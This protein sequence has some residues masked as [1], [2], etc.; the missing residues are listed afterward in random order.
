MSLR[1]GTA[2]GR[3]GCSRGSLGIPIPSHCMRVKDYFTFR[4]RIRTWG[5]V[6]AL[7]I[8]CGF[9]VAKGTPPND[10]KS[11]IKETVSG[12][13]EEMAPLLRALAALLEDPL[14]SPELTWDGSNGLYLHLHGT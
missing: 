2:V 14:W 1:S 6:R 5:Q 8:T 7:L 12:W 3:F 4:S 10:P 9:S 13:A 11:S